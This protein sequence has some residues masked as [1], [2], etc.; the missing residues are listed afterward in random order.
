M[1]AWWPSSSYRIVAPLYDQSGTLV[2]V[3]ARAIQPRDPRVLA[4]K[5]SR[6]RGSLFASSH[7]LEVLRGTWR[8]EMRVLFGEGLTDS[9]ALASV[10]PIPVLCAP[11]TATARHGIGPWVEGLEVL[12]ALDRDDAGEKALVPTARSAFE[13]GAIRVRRVCWPTGCKDAVDLV[14]RVGLV[15]LWEFLSSPLPE[16]ARGR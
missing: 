4:P 3:Q 5:G 15:G 12:L 10:A 2:N 7:G 6:L 8:G 13:H 16:V 14:Q 11:G 9:V 1:T